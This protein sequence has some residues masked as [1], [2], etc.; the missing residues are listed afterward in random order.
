[1]I[2][3]VIEYFAE[4]SLIEIISDMTEHSKK[5]KIFAE[6]TKKGSVDVKSF[7]MSSNV[8]RNN[9][10]ILPNLKR[11]SKKA[12]STRKLEISSSPTPLFFT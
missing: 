3:D 4:Y 11:W 2:F 1:M 12:N 6:P 10:K 5:N 8:E 9:N 7:Q